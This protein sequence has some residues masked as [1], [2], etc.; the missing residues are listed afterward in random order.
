[1]E[2][3]AEGIHLIQTPQ[4]ICSNIYIL[5]NKERHL[6]IDAGDGQT[7]IPF[8]PDYTLL[9]HN[10][11]D[12]TTG[13]KPE[14]KNVF[15]H[16]DAFTPRAYSYIPP[17]ALPYNFS[18]MNFGPF[19]LEII[20]TPGHT[21]GGVCIFEK[22]S[23]ILFSGDTKFAFGDRGRTDLGGSEVEI[24]KSLSLIE[25]IDYKLLAPGHGPV[26]KK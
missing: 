25:K 20:H 11:S 8:T 23:K 21:P 4:R 14:W 9:T 5:R 2:K 19:Q 3:I 10:H 16:K 1:M 7:S 13:V 12:H 15:L 22:N 18:E 6:I 26:E 24:M 17:N